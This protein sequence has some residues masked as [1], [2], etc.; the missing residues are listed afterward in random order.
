M[1]ENPSPHRSTCARCG[2]RITPE[3]QNLCA[4]CA[5]P[6]VTESPACVVCGKTGTWPFCGPVCSSDYP[7][8]VLE[9]MKR[10]KEMQ[11]HGAEMDWL[12]N[13]VDGEGRGS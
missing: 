7:R 2:T 1:L 9:S 3:N 6:L 12:A 8:L 5:T 11:P 13:L 10:A 4:A